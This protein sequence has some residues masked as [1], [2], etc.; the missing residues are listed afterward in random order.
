MSLR[1]LF[2]AVLFITSPTYANVFKCTTPEGVTYSQTPCSKDATVLRTS[3][4]ILG[5]WL[6][7]QDKVVFSSDGKGVYYRGGETCYQFTYN[8]IELELIVKADRANKCM[9][10]VESIYYVAMN[11]KN[12]ALIHK[13]SNFKTIW[14]KEFESP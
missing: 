2:I 14:K 11:A 7:K 8:L 12:L 1:I 9:A 10:G 4:P 6:W 13:G 3:N 5:S